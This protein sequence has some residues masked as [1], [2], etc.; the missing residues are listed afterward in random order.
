M[1]VGLLLVSAAT[2]QEKIVL[3]KQNISVEEVFRE[4]EQVMNLSFAYNAD[5]LDASRKL[6]LEKRDYVLTELLERVLEETGH[7]F[8]IEGRHVLI[9]PARKVPEKKEEKKP[10]AAKVPESRDTTLR[11]GI[12]PVT[13]ATE[14]LSTRNERV[15]MESRSRS[16]RRHEIP[17]WYRGVLLKTNLLHDVLLLAPNLVGETR[18]G[19]HISL[20]LSVSLKADGGDGKR[21][22]EHWI[23]K[24]EI[25][26]WHERTGSFWGAYLLYWDYDIRGYS[27]VFL[28]KAY[29][30][31][32]HAL[33][34]GISYGYT[35]IVTPS[36]GLEFNLGL[37]AAW[38]QYRY[39]RRERVVMYNADRHFYF[40][41]T[42]LGLK[43]V[44]KI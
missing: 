1:G 12:A 34:A 19:P 27:L 18:L 28:E 3:S 14:F 5:K 4:I 43:W 15:R 42:S 26:F 22:L 39:G 7:T 8:S 44:Y 17:E 31:R 36:W 20:A 9:L 32:G 2:A 10:P 13:V 11:A 37:G 30:Y 40:G 6:N 21:S 41:P 24:P 23:V 25:R 16:T 29:R 38:M 35:W 33:G